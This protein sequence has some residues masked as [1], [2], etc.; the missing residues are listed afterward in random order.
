MDVDIT[1]SVDI[2]DKSNRRLKHST[3]AI[4]DDCRR[5]SSHFQYYQLGIANNYIAIAIKYSYR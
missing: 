5:C 4:S 3:F 2:R 1:G